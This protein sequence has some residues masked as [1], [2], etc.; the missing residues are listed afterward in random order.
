MRKM[1]SV[2]GILHLGEK[3]CSLPS[4]L[5]PEFHWTEGCWRQDGNLFFDRL[6]ENCT[7][8]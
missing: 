8:Q 4:E 5:V 2:K 3:D 7:E 1:F 6:C